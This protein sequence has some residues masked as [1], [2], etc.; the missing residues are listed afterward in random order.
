[1]LALSPL[2][3]TEI[4]SVDGAVPEGVAESHE[5]FELADQARVP[6]PAFEIDMDCA[7]DAAEPTV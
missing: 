6:P 7:E 5:E 1:M 3:L 2:G 4:A